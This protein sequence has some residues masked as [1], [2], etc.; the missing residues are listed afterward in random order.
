MNSIYFKFYRQEEYRPLP[1]NPLSSPS[2]RLYGQ[3]AGTKPLT[4]DAVDT[5][6][7]ESTTIP[8]TAQDGMNLQPGA[9]RPVCMTRIKFLLTRII[10]LWHLI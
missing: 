3:E 10:T 1:N 6:K 9:E 2:C 7:A 5:A 8:C 4:C